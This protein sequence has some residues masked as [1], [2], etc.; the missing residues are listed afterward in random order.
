MSLDI[1]LRN[2]LALAD[3]AHAYVEKYCILM[4]KDQLE[5]KIHTLQSTIKNIQA[6]AKRMA[7]V[8]N[9]INRILL[10]R[11]PATITET[12]DP[13]PTHRDHAVLRSLYPTESRELVKGIKIPVKIVDSEKEI[14]LSHIYYV[15]DIDQYAINIEGLIIKGNLSNIVE[16]KAPL[17]SRCEYGTSCNS[18]RK[19]KPCSYYHD[20]E[21]Y[22]KLNLPVPANNIR[23]FTVGSWLYSR[24]KKPRTYFT[25]HVGS[26]DTLVNDIESLRKIQYREEISN[27]E[28]QLV[29]DLLVYM[30]LHNQGF[31][32]R[33]S[34]W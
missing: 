27:R 13:Y 15:K 31:I 25:R 11:K 30:V 2:C 14:P 4:S 19:N 21:D 12:I 6:V 17:S 1:S 34:H 20:P 28:G 9:I 18:F 10:S 23:N 26:R 32:E 3:D 7:D 5:E 22:I 16:Y 29:H 33:Y 8:S 24:N